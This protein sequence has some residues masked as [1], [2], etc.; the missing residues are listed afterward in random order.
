MGLKERFEE[1]YDDM[2]TNH[3]SDMLEVDEIRAGYIQRYLEAV[4]AEVGHN[5]EGHY[6]TTPWQFVIDGP[7]R[8]CGEVEP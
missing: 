7:C 5:W 3:Y 6:K 1:I 2:T 8:R 4:C